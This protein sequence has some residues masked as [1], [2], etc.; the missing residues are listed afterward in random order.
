MDR[1][2]VRELRQNASR[3]LDRV[4]AGESI[5]VTEHGRPIAVLGPVV[6]DRWEALIASGAVSP[7]VRDWRELPPPLP[8]R[9]GER[10]ASEL[11]EAMRA[12]ER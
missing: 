4:K 9:S 3:Y 2:G 11:L 8:A 7:A 6:E 5:E 1:I 10:S 12:D